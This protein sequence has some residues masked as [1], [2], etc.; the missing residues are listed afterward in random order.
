MGFGYVLSWDSWWLIINNLPIRYWL[1]DNQL[2]MGHQIKII[3]QYPNVELA[4][5]LWFVFKLV[6][7]I[8]Q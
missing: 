6:I 1:V 7:Y 3:L 8:W 2:K 5:V 4:M